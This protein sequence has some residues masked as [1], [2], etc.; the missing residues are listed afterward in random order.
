MGVRD[1]LAEVFR[2][3]PRGRRR[4]ERGALAEAERERYEASVEL[5]QERL[6]ELELAVE[7]AGWQRLAGESAR[8]FSRDG[9]RRIAALSRLFYL[10]NPLIRRAVTLQATYVWGQG[11]NVHA[12]HP[13]V[14]AVV[15]R[16]LDEPSTRAEL[17]GHQA[18]VLKEIDLQ[19]E[20]NVFL[21][22]F[23]DPADGRV[24]VRSIPPDEVVDIVT[25]PDDAKE[26]WYY[27]RV[28]SVRAF[29][30]ATGTTGAQSRTAYYPDWRYRPSVRPAA[31][32]GSPVEW[33]TPVYHV[34][35]GG[36]SDMRFGVPETYAALDWARAYKAFLE[37]WATITRAL[38]RFAW[39]LTTPGGAKGVAAA[40]ARLGTTL[41]AGASA[42]QM[43]T[44]PPP[45]TGSV[46]I[47]ADGTRLEPVR[48]SGATTSAEDGRRLLLMVAAATGLPETFFGDVSVGTL[49]TARSLD[50]PTELKFRDRQTLWADVLNDLLQYAID[51][52]A[53]APAGPLPAATGQDP[54]ALHVVLGEDPDTGEPIDRYVSI[55][56][57][58]ILEHDVEATVG[59][60]VSAATLGGNPPAGTIDPKLLSKL[61]LTALGQDDVD[62]LLGQM[63]PDEDGEQE[64]APAPT[65]EQPA[66]VLAASV[67]RLAEAVRALHAG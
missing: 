1:W 64:T 2:D 3:E 41:A 27:R 61:L 37:D 44:N 54:E 19:V 13:A 56:F 36:L 9:L 47:G 55:E 30:P 45:V 7:D 60:I 62:E 34:K 31:I 29:D 52:A 33:D 50:R 23:P 6:A 46:F 51:W 53:R 28:W 67:R 32:G 63:Y 10:K 43:E 40:R 39:N 35:V 8:E 24:R 22:L 16:F 12:R 57:P 48:T 5:L 42:E 49:A 21:V 11:L 58:P 20:G 14:D 18:R 4:G 17:T 66:E 59:A 25:N 15:Q 38:S 65:D 26:V